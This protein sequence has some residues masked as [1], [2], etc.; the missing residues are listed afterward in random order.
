MP[1]DIAQA[2]VPIYPLSRIGESLP[3]REGISPLVPRPDTAPEI[4]S[5]INDNRPLLGIVGDSGTG[6][7]TFLHQMTQ[8]TFDDRCLYLVYDV[9]C[10]QGHGALSKKLAHDFHCSSL[11][12]DRLLET[13]GRT[14]AREKQTLIIAIDGINES[15]AVAPGDIKGDIEELGARLPK[16]IKVIYTCRRVYWNVYISPLYRFPSSIYFQSKPFVLGNFSTKESK[17]AF[18]RYREVYAFIGEYNGL[19][20]ELKEKN[21]RPIDAANDGKRI[22]WEKIARFRAGSPDF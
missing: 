3:Q 13:F 16:E 10:L 14:L 2:C 21:P 11:Q 12:V 9:H 4:E 19:R 17:D 5:F 8:N 1:F 6:K 18:L 15:I 20:N 7:T 22:L